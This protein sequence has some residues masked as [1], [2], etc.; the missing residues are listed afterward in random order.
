MPNQL[1][2]NMWVFMLVHTNYPRVR[3][4]VRIM[5]PPSERSREPDSEVVGQN[6]TVSFPSIRGRLISRRKLPAAAGSLMEEDLPHA[7]R[8]HLCVNVNCA[9]WINLNLVETRSY[10]VKEWMKQKKKPSS[11]QTDWACNLNPHSNWL[12]RQIDASDQNWS[13]QLVYNIYHLFLSSVIR[14]IFASLI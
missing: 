8:V 13:I 2:A 14:A 1:I 4:T 5:W 11:Q 12:L 9:I 3:V 7:H 10:K 6:P